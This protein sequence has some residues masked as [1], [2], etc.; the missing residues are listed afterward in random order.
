MKHIILKTACILA[1]FCTPALLVSC[2]KERGEEKEVKASSITISFVDRNYEVGELIELTAEVTPSDCTEQLVWEASIQP[3]SEG[4]EENLVLIES[5]ELG[6]NVKFSATNVGIGFVQAHIGD[7]ASNSLRVDTVHKHVAVEQVVLDCSDL[8]L[9]VDESFM[10][11]FSTI[12]EN[13]DYYSD[14][15]SWTYD[16]NSSVIDCEEDDNKLYVAANGIGKSVIG[17]TVCGKTAWCNVEVVSNYVPAT[18]ISLSS[19]AGSSVEEFSF[20]T[21]TASV[22]PSDATDKSIEWSIADNTI[23]KRFNPAQGGS[24]Q[25]H[26]V[27]PGKT[28]VIAKHQASGLEK[29]I[30]ITVNRK[31]VPVGAVDMGYRV[32]DYPIYFGQTTLNGVYAYG[33][34][35]ETNSEAKKHSGFTWKNCPYAVVSGKDVSFTKYNTEDGK[36]LLEKQDDAAYAKFG[37]NCHTASALNLQWLL[38][39]CQITYGFANVILT[40]KVPGYTASQITIPANGWYDGTEHK[41][42]GQTYKIDSN[43]F[44]I[45]LDAVL[46]STM[47]HG[48]EM[49]CLRFDSR[50]DCN[51]LTPFKR[52]KGVSVLPV[53]SDIIY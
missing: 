33:D 8:K 49:V 10:L 50:N 29:S 16:D 18:G 36:L 15:I 39:N 7:V 6:R 1:G 35:N 2:N 21:L 14:D 43:T 24:I 48:E 9:K 32:A 4:V 28:T 13:A 46:M 22:S 30:E 20:F 51:Y 12:P 42:C 45:I 52:Y 11:S 26:A 37:E 47:C 3:N 38:E 31:A 23:V 17:L 40:S 27:K 53:W 19:S 34:T 25:L 5:D 41:A 44:G